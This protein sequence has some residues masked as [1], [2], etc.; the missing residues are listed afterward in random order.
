MDGWM[1]RKEN[2]MKM[3]LIVLVI[4][5][6]AP[7]TPVRSQSNIQIGL[8]RI[9][10]GN[11]VKAWVNVFKDILAGNGV[12]Q[13]K[14]NSIVHANGR[15]NVRAVSGEHLVVVLPHGCRSGL[16]P[17]RGRT[18]RRLQQHGTRVS[19]CRRRRRRQRC[20]CSFHFLEDTLAEVG[21]HVGAPEV[22]AVLTEQF[23]VALEGTHGSGAEH[24]QSAVAH[25]SVFD[26]QR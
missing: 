14:V 2:K 15:G 8:E 4:G 11:E 13:G 12:H 3:K 18:G 20:G 22:V 19:H 6:M 1:R 5:K 23:A 26:A 24:G 17:R 25:L 16:R 9:L 10:H 7:R 21:H